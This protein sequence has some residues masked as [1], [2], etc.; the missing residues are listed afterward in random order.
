[1]ENFQFQ[2]NDPVETKANDQ[3]RS[4]RRS[5]KKEIIVKR[6]FNNLI[7]IVSLRTCVCIIYLHCEC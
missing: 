4:Q 3:L 2:K 5:Q 6:H 1:M 7:C